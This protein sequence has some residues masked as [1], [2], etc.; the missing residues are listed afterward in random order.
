MKINQLKPERLVSQWGAQRV[1]LTAAKMVEW[2]DVTV[3]GSLAVQTAVQ[4]D[5]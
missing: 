1:V 5:A 2:K 4:L 3:V